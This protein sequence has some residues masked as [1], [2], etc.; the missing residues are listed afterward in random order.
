MEL[1]RLKPGIIIV[2]LQWIIAWGLPAVFPGPWTS[3]IGVLGGMALGLALMVWWAFISKA[4][5]FERWSA[6]V[7][8]IFALAIASGLS[9]ESIRTAGQGIMFFAHTIPLSS[10]GFMIWAVSCRKLSAGPRRLTMAA[11]I[12]LTCF[13]GTLV[14]SEGMDGDSG[15]DL[16][17][18][19]SESNEE[20][21]LAQSSDEP[22]RGA[23]HALLPETKAEWPGFRGENRNSR[24]EGT[25]IETDWSANPPEEVWRRPVGPG[26]SS[27]AVH[28]PLMF[29]QEQQ[30]EDE[31]LACYDLKGGMVIWKYNYQARFWDSHAG[32]G[33]RGTPTLSAGR[34]YTLGATGI[35]NV[36]DE[37]DGSLIWSVNAAEDAHVEAL[38]WG[39][40]SSPLVHDDVVIVA[41]SGKLVAYE[42]HTGKTLWFGNEGGESYSS[43]QLFSIEGVEQVLMMSGKGITSYQASDGKVLWDYPMEGVRIVQP[44]ICANEDLL[45]DVGG[46]RGL[47]RVS[48][49]LESGKWTFQ[50]HWKSTRLKP[51]FNDFVI[52]KG[53]AYG[54][55]GPALACLD[56]EDGQRKWKAG[57]YG[58][59]ILLLADQDLLIVLTEK[60]EL[61][62]VEAIPE[63]HREVA[64]FPAIE[65][66]TWN[67]PVMIGDLLLVRN[68][69]E[70]AAFR[71]AGSSH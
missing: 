8:W 46:A 37:L 13:A 36:L 2:V 30:G 50:E 1:K 39:F 28:G 6:I 34:V 65:G 59:Q 45:I 22:V 35:L 52:H 57:R 27:F 23:M 16:A 60:G 20:K 10:L 24:I 47:Q 18:R 58:G 26:C 12:L 38:E 17:W 67:H 49:T 43:P 61:V 25:A 51:N 3:T 62:L 71:L 14:R 55:E 56:L 15:L 53:H 64:R 68:M 21:F 19:W 5:R 33:P 4:P 32:A 44:A 11:A 9:H 48:V 66:K 63:K 70:M 7:L 29:T 41:I 40:A 31:V 54:F 42:V 69:T